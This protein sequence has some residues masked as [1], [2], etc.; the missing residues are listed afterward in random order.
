MKL[1][2]ATVIASL[3]VATPMV[4]IAQTPDIDLKK[5]STE[6]IIIDPNIDEAVISTIIQSVAT[7]ADQSQFEELKSLF[8]DQ[9]QVDY[10]SLF[11]GEI[12]THTPESLMAA[13]AS[14]L[15]GFDQ[16]YHDLSNIQVDVNVEVA[17]A[18]AD[19][20][21]S[22][23]IDGFFWQVSGEYNYQFVRDNDA[24]RIQ[25]MTFQVS[26]EKGDRVV[27]EKAS[28]VAASNSN[29]DVQQQKTEQVIR[30]FLTGLETRNTETLSSIWSTNAVQE[31]PYAPEGF[32][33]R[34]EG[35]G[36]LSEHYQ[37]WTEVSDVTHFADTLVLYTT[38]DPTTVLA[39]WQG[40]DNQES[41]D[42]HQYGGL[43]QISDNKIVLFREYFTS[44]LF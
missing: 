40:V 19:V 3:M 9:I 32:P 17:A 4:A 11:G 42:N 27:F 25:A 35:A 30:N 31:I 2:F 15:P 16:T 43:F 10:T 33:S 22:H 8:A 21:A 39:E 18:T 13:W 14:L 23:Y 29:Q 7:F 20:T 24:W 44:T 41:N 37:N 1:L 6:A 34:I 28:L 38:Q 26:Q 36:N 5:N 12:Q